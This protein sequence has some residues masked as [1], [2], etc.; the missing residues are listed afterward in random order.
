MKSRLL[1]NVVVAQSAAILELF[2]VENKLLLVWRDTL[3]V[4][5]LGLHV[6]DSVAGLDFQGDGLAGKRL[7]EDLHTTAQ[8]KNQVKS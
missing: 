6:F 1:L 2:S 5:D 4:L 7:H 3:L 8:T